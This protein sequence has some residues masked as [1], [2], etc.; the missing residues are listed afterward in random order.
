M[1]RLETSVEIQMPIEQVFA[2]LIEP[3]NLPEWIFGL[4]A[5]KKYRQVWS[6]AQGSARKNGLIGEL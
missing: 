6:G 1:K 4:M 5:G 3:S 2:F